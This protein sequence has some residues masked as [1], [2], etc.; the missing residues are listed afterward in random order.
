MES[1]QDLSKILRRVQ[2][3]INMAEG[4]NNNPPDS[5]EWH[6]LNEEQ[7][8]ARER[9]DALMLDYAITEA[10]AQAAKP[11]EQRTKGVVEEFDVAHYNS[12]LYGYIVT[13][14]RVVAKFT[15]CIVRSYAGCDTERNVDFGRV[16]GY[17]SD[18]RYFQHLYTTLR[19]HMVG[20][21]RPEIDSALSLDVNCYNLHSAG[22]GW[23]EIAKM[24]GWKQINRYSS[25]VP[26][27]FRAPSGTVWK[28][29]DGKLMDGRLMAR[30][31][32][33]A[34]IRE[35][36]R[37]GEEM[38]L[39]IN[40]ETYR[41]SAADGYVHRIE[42][43]MEDMAAMRQ[44]SNALEIRITDLEQF[45][46]ESNP[47]QFTKC[48]ECGKFS[49]YNW[50]CDVCG[51]QWAEPPASAV[52]APCPKCAKSKRGFCNEHS[53]HGMRFTMPKHSEAGYRAGVSR[54]NTADIGGQK[55]GNRARPISNS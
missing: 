27:D 8:R 43:R 14:S 20:A 28:S 23:R 48:P 31:Y 32:R 55:V 35:Y 51:H 11:S 18:V 30:I 13:L 37:R 45:Y 44:T 1:T 10:M 50:K 22:M 9:A 54:A 24:Y 12:D 6:A 36:K 46:R 4:S 7:K 40:P 26:G 2:Q 5:P 34:A 47:Q 42:R 17:E 52:F 33:S 3:L 39:N 53:N 15:R 16:Y 29:A 41:R 19:L 49:A 38:P 25:E 21:L